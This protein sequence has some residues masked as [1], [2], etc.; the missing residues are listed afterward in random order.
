ML[1][2]IRLKT[3]VKRSRNSLFFL[4][5]LVFGGVGVGCSSPQGSAVESADEQANVNVLL[6]TV[7][8]LRP[9]LGAY[10]QE[11]IVSPNID[12]LASKGLLF[13]R[14]YVHQ[15]VCAPSRIS[16]MT[17]LRPDST[18]AYAWDTPLREATPQA[19]TLPQHFKQYGYETLSVRGKVFPHADGDRKAWTRGPI[20]VTGDWKGWGYLTEDAVEEMKAYSDPTGNRGPAFESAE[21]PDTAYEDGKVAVRAVE[22]LKQLKNQNRPFFLAVGFK[23]PHLPFNAPQKYWDLYSSEKV[24]LPENYFPPK[25]ATKYSLTNF[26]ELRAYS[27]MPKEGPLPAEKAK[28]LIRGYYASVSYMDAQVGRILGALTQFGLRDETIILLWSDHGFKL[29]EHGSWSKHTNFEIDTRIP[30]IVSAPGMEAKGRR[31]DALVETVDV[32]P[33]LTELAG[34]PEPPQQQGLSF[35]PLLDNPDQPWKEAVFSQYR[36]SDK[37]GKVMGYSIRTDRYRYVEWEHLKS[38]EIRA[39]E[40]YDHRTDPQENVNVAAKPSYSSTVERLTRMLDRGWKAA[41]PK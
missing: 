17:G 23:K 27:N 29:G 13:E 37:D 2:H 35:A 11:D 39:R 4:L 16:L 24:E 41:V 5:L 18:D 21:V 7:D 26:G 30:L 8:D 15:T 33:T 19:V 31:T 3:L 14:A 12:R 32:Y 36:R 40:L 22:E 25:G 28:T 10:G 34:L 9:E 6:I 1:T 38:G 20:Q